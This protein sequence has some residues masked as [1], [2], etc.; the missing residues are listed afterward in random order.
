MD[1]FLAGLGDRFGGA[2]AWALASG[3]GAGG[4]ERMEELLL[5][6]PTG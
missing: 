4:L 1:R 3:R 5:E 2:R 6:P